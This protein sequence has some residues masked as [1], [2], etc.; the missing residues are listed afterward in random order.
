LHAVSL[1]CFAG[2]D[3]DDVGADRPDRER[4]G[5]AGEHVGVPEVAVG[6]QHL[7][8]HSRAGGVA[9]GFARG[10]PERVV[11]RRE[12]R[13]RAGLGECGGAGQRAGLAQQD[14]QVVVQVEDLHSL[15][16][17]ALVPRHDLVTVE[18]RHGGGGQ[19]DPQPVADEPGRDAVLVAAH[20]HLRVAV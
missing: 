6:Q 1:G 11:G 5:D 19:F 8:Q 13:S 2:L 14:L 10:G 4:G 9:E 15:A 20:H 3:R 7:D 16:D 18:H 12:Y 17:R